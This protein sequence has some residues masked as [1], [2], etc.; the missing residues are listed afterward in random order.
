ML[1]TV[2]SSNKIKK[3]TIDLTR[4]HNEQTQSKIISMINTNHLLTNLKN[5][6]KT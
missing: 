1:I 5:V 3:L 2:Y 4:F 6:Q